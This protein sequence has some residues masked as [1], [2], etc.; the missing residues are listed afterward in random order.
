MPKAELSIR[1]YFDGQNTAKEEVI[2]SLFEKMLR[3]KLREFVYMAEMADLDSDFS[4]SSYYT[5]SIKI[6]GFRDSFDKFVSPYLKEIL[7]FTPSDAKLFDTLKEKQRK[8]YANF[9]LNNPYQLAYESLTNALREGSGTSPS[10]K[11]IEAEKITLQDV[12]VFAQAWKGKFY[13][14][15]YMTGNTTEQ[16][17]LQIVKTIE[18]LAK[19]H[20]SPLAKKAIGTIRPIF[21]PVGKVCAVE[22]VLKSKEESNNSLIVHFQY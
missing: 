13:L 8:E 18:D 15:T 17:S 12:A 21:L 3:E 2:R 22:E 19:L 11:M 14:E 5:A 20:S 4:F 6:M 16:H 1:L 7:E 9:F 10:E